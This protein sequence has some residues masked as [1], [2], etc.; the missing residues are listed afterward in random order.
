VKKPQTSAHNWKTAVARPVCA[1][2]PKSAIVSPGKERL[3]ASLTSKQSLPK[4]KACARFSE[5][6]YFNNQNFGKER[7]GKMAGYASCMMK[8]EWKVA[9]QN[10]LSNGT[11]I[12]ALLLS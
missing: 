5:G 10:H 11:G 9:Q 2:S 7:E 12:G 8:K 3:L 4:Q 6:F 1:S